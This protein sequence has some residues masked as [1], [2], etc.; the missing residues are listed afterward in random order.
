MGKLSQTA[1]IK[2]NRT[3]EREV[4]TSEHVVRA[5]ELLNSFSIP[6]K[7]FSY[8]LGVS[9]RYVQMMASGE[10]KIQGWMI[11]QI[12][13]IGERYIWQQRELIDS[14]I[15]RALQESYGVHNDN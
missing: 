6:A 3:Y 1:Q 8:D 14:Y 11:N 2:A 15:R 4:R 13:E 7:T 12:I 10:K 9:E 5:R